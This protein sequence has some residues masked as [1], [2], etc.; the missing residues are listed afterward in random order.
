G[1]VRDFLRVEKVFET[2]RPDIVF[3]AAAHKHVPL[4]ETSPVEA[5]KN[6]VKG[7]YNVALLSLIYNTKRFVLIS[8]DKAV[9]PTSVMGATKRIC[10][11]IIQGLNDA[12]ISRNYKNLAKINVQDG[13]RNI[14]IEPAEKLAGKDHRT[15]FVAVR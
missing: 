9:N 13:D 14:I 6:N 4:M 1:S 15:E 5:I 12:K 2:Y 7:T 8:T 11:K 10:E 3:H